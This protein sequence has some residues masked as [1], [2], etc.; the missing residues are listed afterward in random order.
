MREIDDRAVGAGVVGPVT[1]RIQARFF[2]VARGSDTSH[3]EWLTR[4]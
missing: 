2:E 1:R 3:P 4:V